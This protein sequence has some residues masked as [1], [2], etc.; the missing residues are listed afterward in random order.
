VNVSRTPPRVRNGPVVQ[1]V[2][3]RT[4]ASLDRTIVVYQNFVKT[5]RLVEWFL[6]R[7]LPEF[8]ATNVVPTIQDLREILVAPS[9]GTADWSGPPLPFPVIEAVADAFVMLLDAAEDLDWQVDS[10]P[11]QDLEPITT[12]LVFFSLF[13]VAA[14]D[15]D[16]RIFSF[17]DVF[18]QYNSPPNPADAANGPQA[19]DH[20]L[21]YRLVS[22]P[23]LTAC[24]VVLTFS[25]LLAVLQ[26]WRTSTIDSFFRFVFSASPFLWQGVA[27]AN[28]EAYLQNLCSASETFILVSF[29][30]VL[31]TGLLM[32]SQIEMIHR[33]MPCWGMRPSGMASGLFPPI[34]TRRTSSCPSGRTRRSSSIVKVPDGWYASLA[35]FLLRSLPFFFPVTK[36][37][38][39]NLTVR[40]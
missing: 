18:W 38:K 8:Q 36:S 10:C 37:S 16:S 39:T 7:K 5:V 1:K 19:Y 24:I 35:P 25:C 23:S 2:F 27:D 17:M 3:R 29:P 26:L 34:S 14:I 33:K 30:G 6:Q 32:L 22:T 4:H 15:W 11:C 31:T 28:P 21:Y 12:K 9:A 20:H 13:L 40:G